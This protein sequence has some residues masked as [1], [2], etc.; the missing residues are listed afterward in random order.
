[1]NIKLILE[2]II[3]GIGKIIPGVSGSVIAVS[4]G[5][6]DKLISCITN[7]FD[8][9]KNNFKFLVNFGIGV[10]IGI[11]FFSKVIL[12]FLNNYY[13]LTMCLFVGI[14]IGGVSGIYKNCNFSY[15][16]IICFFISFLLFL[17]LCNTGDGNDY[18]INGTFRDII[19]YF[20]AGIVE[21]IG[22]IIP[23]IS[24]SA[25]LMVM[26]VYNIFIYSISNMFSISFIISNFR[27]L[28]SFGIGL[29]ISIIMCIFLINYLFKKYRDITFSSIL[30]IVIGNIIM[31]IYNIIKIVAIKNLVIV[32]ILLGIGF[33]IGLV[34]S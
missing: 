16:G 4:F 23:G 26:G 33:I 10:L 6:Y 1:M 9:K 31:I 12:Y 30:G 17:I 13:V 20:I 11:V 19:I 14:I 5:L 7:F 32:V 3:V 15:K 22:T 8:D 29:F 24:S 18:V 21:G 34:S 27:F 28:F 25:M 2:G